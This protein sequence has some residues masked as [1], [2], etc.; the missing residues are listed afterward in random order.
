MGAD[1]VQAKELWELLGSESLL[2]AVVVAVVAE[3][4][5]HM[6]SDPG[7]TEWEI[8]RKVGIDLFHHNRRVLQETI[9][10]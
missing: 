9:V 3:G 4:Q 5:Q 10:A 2:L 8:G 1:L 7:E 6:H